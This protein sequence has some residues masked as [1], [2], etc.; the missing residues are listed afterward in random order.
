M[1]K[2]R[3]R[4][5]AVLEHR[6]F[7][8]NRLKSELA[9]I[10]REEVRERLRLARLIS[11][12]ENSKRALLDSLSRGV[13]ASE[14]ELL[15]EYVKTK[16]DDVRVQQLTVESIKD[17]VESKRHEVLEAIKRRKLLESLRDKQERCYLYEAARAEQKDLDDSATVRFARQRT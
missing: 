16:R 3:F 12:L 13:P 1:R 9:E 17:R 14:L 6:R 4:L 5:Q 15:D 7:E 2:F 8:E 11:E 10:M